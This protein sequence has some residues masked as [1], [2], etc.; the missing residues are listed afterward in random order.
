MGNYSHTVLFMPI[1]LSCL[2]L[3]CVCVCVCVCFWCVFVGVLGGLTLHEL[4]IVMFLL[5]T[6]S[7]HEFHFPFLHDFF[8]F[9]GGG[10]GGGGGGGRWL[11]DK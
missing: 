3:R 6:K 10:G 2:L 11:G 5:Y 7:S 1:F 8:S 9:L 4:E